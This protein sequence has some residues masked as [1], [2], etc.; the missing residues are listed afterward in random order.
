ME[1]TLANVQPDPVEQVTPTNN[2]SSKSIY[3]IAGVVLL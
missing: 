3:Y 1:Y 2:K